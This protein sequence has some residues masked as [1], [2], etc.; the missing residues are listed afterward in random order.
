MKNNLAGIGDPYWYEWSV[1]LY[2]LVD[3]LNPDTQI[4]SVTF[5]SSDSQCLDDVVI[6][7]QDRGHDCIQVKHTRKTD[8][9]TF[10]DIRD[11]LESMA[12]DWQKL[13]QRYD[14]CNPILFSNKK[15]H[16]PEKKSDNPPIE[17]FWDC[18]TELCHEACTILEVVFSECNLSPNDQALYQTG[19]ELWL[20]KVSHLSEIEQLEF[21]K[22]FTIL[23]GQPDLAT[24]QE[25]IASKIQ[26]ALCSTN[27][28]GEEFVIKL[29]GALWQWT[30]SERGVEAITKENVFKALSIHSDKIQGIHNFPPT[31]PFFPSR[32][33]FT[34]LLQQSLETRQKPIVFLHGLPGSGKTNVVSYLAN[35]RDTCITLRFH[36]FKPLN[37]HDLGLTA[38]KGISSPRDF[39]ANLLIELREIFA[40]YHKLAECNIPPTVALITETDVLRQKVLELS[41]VLWELTGKITVIA[42]DGIDHAARSGDS[43]TFL[44][45]L[46]PPKEVPPHVC[47]LIAGQPITEY[48]EYPS[49]LHEE[50]GVL[51]CEVPPVEKTDILLLVKDW[52]GNSSLKKS[53]YLLS[54]LVDKIQEISAGNTLATVFAV[55]ELKAS[56]NIETF[57][58]EVQKRKLDHGIEQYYQYIWEFAKENLKENHLDLFLIGV[59]SLLKKQVSADILHKIEPQVTVTGWESVLRNL[60]PLVIPSENG[61]YS[62]FHNDIRIFFQKKLN[63][64]PQIIGR[65]SAQLA[66]YLLSQTADISLKHLQLFEFL[67][68]ARRETE[69]I[70]IFTI[71]YVLE[72]IEARC[73]W[74]DMIDQLEDT[75]LSLPDALSEVDDY[76]KVLGLSCAVSTLSQLEQVL[77]YANTEYPSE[78][79]CP[80]VFPSEQK[81]VPFH[82]WTAEL[83]TTVFDETSQ[84][85][86]ENEVERAR[87][88]LVRWMSGITPEMLWAKLAIKEKIAPLGSEEEYEDDVKDFIFEK[89]L[90]NLLKNWGLL[91]RST[92][93]FS[94]VN[95]TNVEERVEREANAAFMSGWLEEGE[96]HLSLEG[97]EKTLDLRCI[98]KQEDEENYFKKVLE[99][100]NN[101]AIEYVFNF[102]RVEGTAD[103]FI[104]LKLV[105]WAMNHG[106]YEQ[107]LDWV[108]EINKE[109]LH[110]FPQQNTIEIELERQ[111]PYCCL[112]LYF[113]AKSERISLEDMVTDFQSLP[114]GIYMKNEKMYRLLIHNFRLGEYF[115]SLEDNSETDFTS[116]EMKKILKDCFYG[117]G[118][119]IWSRT[120]A[121]EVQKVL[122]CEIIF[123]YPRLDNSFQEAIESAFVEQAEQTTDLLHFDLWWDFLR[124]KN[125]QRILKKCFQR[126]LGSDG[127]LW[128][129][130]VE[131]ISPAG[132]K[133]IAKA[134]ELGWNEEV[135]RAEALLSAK[136][137]GYV[138]HKDYSFYEFL[139][140]YEIA[141]GNTGFD[142]KNSG[143]LLLNL[144]NFASDTG[145]NRG[146]ASVDSVVA[147]SAALNG[148]TEFWQFARLN[149]DWKQYWLTVIFDGI[150]G[151]METISLTK[152]ELLAIWEIALEVFFILPEEVSDVVKR[153]SGHV[154]SVIYLTDLR[155]CLLS[156]AK[157]YAYNIADSMCYLG[158][159]QFELEI[160]DATM[161]SYIV[162]SRWFRN[163]CSEDA[164]QKFE[165]E[166]LKELFYQKNNK[167]TWRNLAY[168]MEEFE[169]VGQKIEEYLDDIFDMLKFKSVPMWDMDGRDEIYK[170]IFKYFDKN[171]LSF[172]LK[173]IATSYVNCLVLY[174]TR[175]L[176]SL[177]TDLDHFTQFFYESIFPNKGLEAFKE[178]ATMHEKWVTAN[179]RLEFKGEY[180]LP[181]IEELKDWSHFCFKLW[182]EPQF[183]D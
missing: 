148:P 16:V 43:N 111:F 53:G 145:N 90:R 91:A 105:L 166:E 143:L 96:N 44:S 65:T 94:D 131:N 54:A 172:A 167:F 78:I 11:L 86:A 63:K 173:E 101:D 136:M 37:P 93:V 27:E 32:V 154:R 164:A 75:L 33:D 163:N 110:Y 20:S 85:C 25:K 1:G 123:Y 141:H 104:Q 39:W 82:S 129:W 139:N 99:S 174:R 80:A 42:V 107:C 170:V 92:G 109:R 45:T 115:R 155:D 162:P 8:T 38:D 147:V 84:L 117:A 70:D 177:K 35:Q 88:N 83:L 182:T 119:L 22:R 126:W 157:K 6:E 29:R 49:F 72:A 87:E 34:S 120:S 19:W 113:L 10:V 169:S 138:G 18:V 17:P 158:Q 102:L 21:F 146:A 13:S 66:D 179:G 46:I 52:F 69:F 152:E 153:S 71:D 149:D 116:A 135:K 114:S 47:F 98:Y 156:V 79:P 81:V 176:R 168:L 178:V 137:L 61:Y 7:Y 26:A 50:D 67:K 151:A 23:A 4:K 140:F 108:A 57:F 134:R 181:D 133:L 76:Q 51:L 58:T 124:G 55:E 40:G 15:F 159:E 122:I 160:P 103:K 128:T 171:D 97:I 48:K 64:S 24:L 77:Q 14:Y 121:K 112:V 118:Y 62:L 36:A 5:Q 95:S 130:A 100:N 142:W 74:E 3:I 41:E 106:F 144:S 180:T 9:L 161:H 183:K 175:E 125:K 28:I 89:K 68:N 2:Y 30:T 60:F 56:E 31:V 132:E 150:M 59:F 165:F 127:F 73:P 12:R